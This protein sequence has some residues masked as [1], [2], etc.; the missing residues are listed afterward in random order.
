MFG[1]DSTEFLIVA[2]AALIFIGPNEL[3]ATSTRRSNHCSTI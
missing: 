3:P 2:I 1:V